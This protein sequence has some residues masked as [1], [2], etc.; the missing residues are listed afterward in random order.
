MDLKFLKEGRLSLNRDTYRRLTKVKSYRRFIFT[1]LVI[2]VLSPFIISFTKQNS[3]A[4]TEEFCRV[5]VLKNL[6]GIISELGASADVLRT[7]QSKSKRSKKLIGHYHAA[8]SYYKQI[9]FFTEYYSPFDS[10][11]YINGPLVPKIEMEIS[12][13]PFPP[14]GFQV[15]EENLFDAGKTDFEVLEREYSLLIAKL[16]VLKEYYSTIRIERPKIQDALKLQVI[17]I[18]CLTMNGYDCTINKESNVECSYALDGIEKIISTYSETSDSETKKLFSKLKHT[19][20]SCRKAL[21]KHKDSD[22]FDRLKLTTEQLNPLYRDLVFFFAA[23]KTEKSDLYY[24]VNLK[25]ASFFEPESINKQYFSVYITDSSDLKSQAALGKLLFFDPILSGNNKRACASCHQDNKGFTD[26]QDKSMTFDQSGKLTRNVPTL[27]NAA[28]QKLFF[29]DG[30]LFNLEEQANAVFKNVHEMNSD[31]KEVLYKLAQSEEYKTLFSSAFRGTPDTVITT[32]AVLKCLSEFIKTLDS[33]NSKFDK[34]LR[35]DR[36]QL[37]KEEINGYNLF[38]G[39]ALCGSCHFFPLFN[40][41]VPPMYNDNEF[42]VIGTP[43][44]QDNKNL[45]SDPGRKTVTSS[46]IHDHAFKTPTLR[47][48]AYTAPYM[49][50]GVYDNLDSVLVFYNRGGGAGV[51]LKVENQTLPFDS[52]GLSK[53]ELHDIK[54]FLLTL[55]DTTGLQGAPKKLPSFKNKEFN[56]RKI[57]GE[58]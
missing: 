1:C 43:E 46:I 35:G 24:A 5:L 32:Y 39:K 53:K 26:G 33:H 56:K 34:Y 23:L 2:L 47:N 52:L 50:N 21:L 12:G 38:A 30:R 25:L 51:G 45:D 54:S 29:H 22:S 13:K 11:F 15:I 14:Q 41:T 58:Y 36:S 27:I 4:N 44:K 49:H 17:R 3:S 48:I 10:K 40:G 19:L 55:S 7:E 20:G 16:S 6:S 57:G 8:R 9:E 42:E 37:N 28:Y 31:E 18:M